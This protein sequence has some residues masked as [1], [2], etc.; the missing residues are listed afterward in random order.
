M[1]ELA[2][3]FITEAK[4]A[5]QNRK[6]IDAG[7]CFEKAAETILQNSQAGKLFRKA[8]KIYRESGR[9]KEADRCY[10]KAVQLLDGQQKAE[11]LLDSWIDLIDTIVHFEYDCSF[12]WRG[13]TDGSHDSYHEDLNQIQK[14]AEGVLR[15]AL[16]VKGADKETIIE[17]ASDE[18]K[19]R[20]KAGGWGAS[21]C[22][23]AIRNAT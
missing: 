21:R 16:S 2:K 7:R 19:K 17:K 13:E 1:N 6:Y 8:S 10:Q 22:W 9:Y 3:R 15:Q 4:A 14:K 5:L 18:C 12:E 11:C 20:E 23:H